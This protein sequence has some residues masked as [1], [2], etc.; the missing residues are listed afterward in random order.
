MKDENT[1]KNMMN[2]MEDNRL[3]KWNELN[4]S[5]HSTEKEEE[6][7]VQWNGYITVVQYF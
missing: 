6:K 7:D 5:D 1:G 4:N 3:V 2:R